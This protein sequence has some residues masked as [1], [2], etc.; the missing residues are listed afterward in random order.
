MEA[1]EGVVDVA[2]VQGRREGRMVEASEKYPSRVAAPAGSLFRV[3]EIAS[4]PAATRGV[5]KSLADQPGAD[6]SAC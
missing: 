6:D 3:R 4:F 5:M 2:D 1:E